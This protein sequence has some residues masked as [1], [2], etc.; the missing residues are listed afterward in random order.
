MGDKGLGKSERVKDRTLALLAL[1]F[2]VGLIGF[3][4][5]GENPPSEQASGSSFSATQAVSQLKSIVGEP[6]AHPT[7]SAKNAEELEGIERAVQG[8]GYRAERQSAFLCNDTNACFQ[9]QNLIVRIPG[10][11]NG[12]GVLVDAH[13][14]SVPAGPGIADNGSGVAIALEIARQIHL[15][16]PLKY[17]VVLLF[18]DAEAQGLLG[19]QAFV[20]SEEAREVA[21]AIN[22][23]AR[24][25]RGSSLVYQTSKNNAALLKLY[26]RTTRYPVANSL[27]SA[28]YEHLPS[29]TDF[30]NLSAH[31]IQGF[32]LAFLGGTAFYHRSGDDFTNLDLK[33]VQHQGE[34]ALALTRALATDPPSLSPQGDDVYFD[35]FRHEIVWSRWLCLALIGVDLALLTFAAF[36]R[37]PKLQPTALFRGAATLVLTL[38]LSAVCGC[39]LLWAL[40]SNVFSI[41]Q[42]PAHPAPAMLAFAFLG[43]AIGTLIFRLVPMKAFAGIPRRLLDH[44]EPCQHCFAFWALWRKLHH[45]RPCTDRRPMP[46]G[47]CHQRSRKGRVG[48]ARNLWFRCRRRFTL[49]SSSASPVPG[50]RCPCVARHLLRKQRRRAAFAL[51]FLADRSFSAAI[52]S[53]CSYCSVQQSNRPVRLQL[54]LYSSGRR[55]APLD[56]PYAEEVYSAGCRIDAHGQLHARYQA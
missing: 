54:F 29:D 8:L 19:S 3:A 10:Q 38:L 47:C 41:P 16:P 49:D 6:S 20:N 12:P 53:D 15:G 50:R 21:W 39:A 55:A 11:T 2:V 34:E 25:V 40:Y 42:L 56:S 46:L 52:I 13:Y 18:D 51:V 36:F 44:R 7:G 27:M 26:Q 24:G 22:L 9:L 30:T 17:P 35:L 32:N 45:D 48:V 1:V 4:W 43:L 23:D 31:G 37:A 14:D 5:T 28:A 33:S